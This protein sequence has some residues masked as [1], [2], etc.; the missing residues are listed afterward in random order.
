MKYQIGDRV[1]IRHDL[2]SGVKYPH[3][4][5]SLFCN[6]EMTKYKGMIATITNVESHHCIYEIDLD[7]QWDYWCESMFAPVSLNKYKIKGL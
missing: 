1:R 3:V 2:E 7:F 6:K 4:G 5:G